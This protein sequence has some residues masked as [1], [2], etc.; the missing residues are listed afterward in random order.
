MLKTTL[1][2]VG[3]LALSSS[4]ALADCNYGKTVQTPVPPVASAPTQTPVP[5]EPVTQ[6][7][8]EAD[9]KKTEDTKPN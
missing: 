1:T 5:A 3:V 7:V 4:L 8:A 6:D 2:T 9:I